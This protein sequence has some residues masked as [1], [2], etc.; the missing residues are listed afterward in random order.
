MRPGPHRKPSASNC[1][2]AIF[3]S[4]TREQVLLRQRATAREHAAAIHQRLLEIAELA[5]D[6]IDG[7]QPTPCLGSTRSSSSS[8]TTL[9]TSTVLCSDPGNGPLMSKHFLT[10]LA[11]GAA[12]MGA[13][14][15][16]RRNLAR[17]QRLTGIIPIITPYIDIETAEGVL[18]VMERLPE[19]R[20]TIVLHTLGGCVTACVLIANALRQFRD[21][22]AVVP[23]M[24]IS[25]GTLIALSATRL[26]MGGRAS[27]S[28]VDPQI[29]GQ[30][31]KHLAE[32]KDKPSIAALAGSTTWRCASTSALA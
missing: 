27:L 16:G 1:S 5:S 32:S 8:V 6:A 25:G 18:A 30:R 23:Y 15:I 29:M 12:L 20:V 24:A 9:A 2:S 4:I 26:E 31:V 10:G 19:E 17:T 7:D 22:T 14:Y 28:A 11:A 21:S 13:G 3:G